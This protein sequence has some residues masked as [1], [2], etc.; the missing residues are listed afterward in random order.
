MS[1]ELGVTAEPEILCKALNAHD[2]FIVI[3]SDGVFEFL[4]SQNVVD[5]VKKF[6]DPSQAC[7]ALVEE[8][9]ARWLQY[10]V[11]TDDITAICIYLDGLTAN[12]DVAR[13][14]IYVGGEVLD[15]MSMQRP[16]RGI[17]KKDYGP[18]NTIVGTEAIRLSLT[19]GLFDGEDPSTLY[20]L[21]DDSGGEKSDSEIKW[22]K[23]IVQENFLFNH[24]SDVKVRPALAAWSVSSFVLTRS[25]VCWS[26]DDVD[27]RSH[28][29]AEA[30]GG[31]SWR[32]RD[33]SRRARRHVLLGMYGASRIICAAATPELTSVCLSRA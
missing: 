33:P 11:R 6:D 16:V 24:L 7:H 25:V 19:E 1:E 31:R 23:E 13:G 26:G 17:G 18:R 2:K 20:D 29:G 9:Y 15:L 10:E 21:S 8:A 4:T 28:L 5:I 12:R 30:R 27:P 3:A 14:S 22:I 32:R